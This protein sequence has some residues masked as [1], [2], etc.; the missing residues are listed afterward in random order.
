MQTAGP[1]PPL[2]TLSLTRDAS[3]HATSPATGHQSPDPHTPLSP[4]QK[5]L[6]TVHRVPGAEGI[7]PVRYNADP[8]EP[9]VYKAR[10]T[11][12]ATAHH[13]RKMLPSDLA[14]KKKSDL[15][16]CCRSNFSCTCQA[17]TREGHPGLWH[18]GRSRR[19]PRLMHQ[20]PGYS[21]R[22]QYFLLS[23]VHLSPAFLPTN[24]AL[25]REESVFS[26]WSPCRLMAV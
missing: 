20:H 4:T 16:P 21:A 8:G 13:P 24:P 23:T 12:L 5:L 22:E 15:P 25:A 26:A 7:Q 3:P 1:R 11:C 18:S 17:V 9:C 19:A 14:H 2:D 6:L 10:T